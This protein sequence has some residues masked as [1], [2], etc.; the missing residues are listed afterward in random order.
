VT[1]TKADVHALTAGV[2]V[3]RTGA[4]VQPAVHRRGRLDAQLV[5][6]GRL[7]GPGHRDPPG[8][9]LRVRG[10]P[11]GR[12]G[13]HV[14][15]G[16]GTCWPRSTPARPC[17]PP[18]RQPGPPLPGPRCKPTCSPPHERSARLAAR[19]RQFEHRL[20]DALG[21]QVWRESGLGQPDDIGQLK[22]QVTRLAEENQRLRGGLAERDQDLAA[23]RAA[24][25]ELM[26]RL[27]TRS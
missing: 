15:V 13:R 10:L 20:S 14:L 3:A 12:G 17:H 26:A 16:E 24:S 6:G 2:R 7:R 21:E 4:R 8:G 18:G 27:N 1:T 9:R 25:R 23:A 19:I 11:R 5:A 22:Q